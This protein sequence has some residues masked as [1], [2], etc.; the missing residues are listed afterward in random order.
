MDYL[1]KY[2]GSKSSTLTP[3]GLDHS[4]PVTANYALGHLITQFHDMKLQFHIVYQ[5][6]LSLLSPPAAEILIFQGHPNDTKLKEMDP[7]S[8]FKGRLEGLSGLGA[9]SDHRC[10]ILTCCDRSKPSLPPFAEHSFYSSAH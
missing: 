7:C 8:G 10:S 2:D 9:T 5:V 1:L 3:H 4:K 6:I